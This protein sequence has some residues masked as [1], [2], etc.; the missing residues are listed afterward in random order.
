MER[1]KYPRTPHLPWSPGASADDLMAANTSGLSG[2]EVVVTEKMDGENTTLYH[3]D[4]GVHARST[5]SGNHPSRTWARRLQAAIA[6]DI[7]PGWRVCGENMQ[8]V[9]SIRYGD[10]P[11]DCCY[12]LAF[13]VFDARNLCLSW[14]E[15]RQWANLLGLR[16]V[17]I[18]Y[19][20]RWDECAIRGCFLGRS[21]FGGEQ[22]GYVVRA[23]EAFPFADHGQR[24]AKY[25]R[26]GH[27]QTDEHWMQRP[28]VLNGLRAWEGAGR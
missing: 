22:E 11:G 2:R 6:G 8:A 7:P 1:T 23:A 19:R 15:T 28:V 16:T 14:D 4:G 9:H 27:V 10:L 3:G 18:L 24:V 25:V 26:A 5:N 21:A 13:A 12:F 17:P 20:G